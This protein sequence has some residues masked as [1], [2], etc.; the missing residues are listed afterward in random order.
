MA[1]TANTVNV[2]QYT[3]LCANVTFKH[4]DGNTVKCNL[5]LGDR[6]YECPSGIYGAGINSTVRET[7]IWDISAIS[8]SYTVDVLTWLAPNGKI[9]IDVH[10]VWLE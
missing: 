10:E 3:K 2:A 4:L 1:R 7:I 6:T 5:S 8:G 9:I